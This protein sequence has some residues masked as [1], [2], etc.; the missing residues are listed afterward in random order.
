VRARPVESRPVQSGRDFVG[1]VEPARRSV[2]SS[3]FAGLVVEYLAR[4]GD[5][6]KEGQPLA[7][8]RTK[9]LDLRIAVESARLKL[10]KEKLRELESGSRPEEIRQARARLQQLDAEVALRQWQLEAANRLYGEKTISEDERR[11]AEL[12]HEA[13]KLSQAAQEAAVDLVVAGPREER[14][15]QARAEVQIEDAQIAELAEQRD[16]YVVTA[17][18]DGWVVTERTEVG[19]WLAVGSPIAEIVYL[20][21][22]DVVVPVS[23]DFAPRLREGQQ[24]RISLDAVP[25]RIFTGPIR[26]IVPQADLRGRT[27]PVRIRLQNVVEDGEP[28]LRA[29]MFAQATISAG[30]NEEGLFVP[31]DAIVLGGPQPMVWAI[32]PESGMANPVPVTLGIAVEDLVQVKGPLQAGVQVV[33]RGNE[34]LMGPT[35]VTILPE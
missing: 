31:K 16:R 29:G 5:R 24:V 23:E 28:L 17:P 6:V 1:N 11:E 12:A 15:E 26:R 19:Q 21:E 13:A 27:F 14:I 3:E 20:D 33:T 22:V 7:K 10:A 2:V 8:L 9:M 34:R 32:D 30:S 25:D 35:P 18:F 4:E